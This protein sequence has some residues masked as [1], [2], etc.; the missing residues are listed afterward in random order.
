MRP[1]SRRV[2]AQDNFSDTLSDILRMQFAEG[3]TALVP[4]MLDRDQ[5]SRFRE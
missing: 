1:V 5:R 4:P 2:N 3:E